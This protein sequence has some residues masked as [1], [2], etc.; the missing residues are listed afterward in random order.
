MT[1]PN[2]HGRGYEDHPAY[3]FGRAECSMC[4]GS[5]VLTPEGEP[6]EDEDYYS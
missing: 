4:K 5:G 2:C 3:Y 1:C 6:L